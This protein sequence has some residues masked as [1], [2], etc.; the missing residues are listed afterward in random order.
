MH[1]VEKDLIALAEEAIGTKV[2]IK[3]S[4]FT[5]LSGG[6]FVD[7]HNHVSELNKLK[8]FGDQRKHFALVYYVNVGDQNCDDPG[9]LKF[10]DP[11]ELILP[12]NGMVII[13][14]AER[15]HSVSYSGNKERTIIGLNFIS[16]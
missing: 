12:T 15:Y 3:E 5:I 2:Y 1:F 8:G 7:K 13:F 9:F 10:Y 4:W 14:P 6:G 16:I 11:E